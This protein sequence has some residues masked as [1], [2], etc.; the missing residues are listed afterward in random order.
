MAAVRELLDSVSAGPA[1]LALLGEAGIG[2]TTVWEAG[3]AAAREAGHAPLTCRPS[4]AE[5]RLSYAGLADLL[6]AVDAALFM[7]L[8][9]PQRRA[10]EAALLRGPGD[11]WADPRAVAAGFLSVLNGLAAS[12]PVLLA[13]DDLQWLDE[14]TRLVVGYAARRCAGPVAVLTAARSQGCGP[15]SELVPRDLA[16]IRRLYLGPLSLGALH[17]V[18]AGQLQRSFSRPILSQIAEVS[19]GNPFFAL[20]LARSMD[21]RRPGVARVPDSLRAA[22]V[23]H[24]AELGPEVRD[25]LLLVSE[26]AAPRLDLVSRALQA[27]EAGALLG[28]AEDAG[29][30]ELSGGLARFTHP[31]LARRVYTEAPPTSRRAAHRRLAEVVDDLEERARHLALAATGPDAA[32]L[33]ALNAGAAQARRRGAPAVAAELLQLALDLGA[34]DSSLRVQAARDH[35]R[36][37]DPVSAGRLAESVIRDLGSGPARAEA[38]G[39]LGAIRYDDYA[40][41]SRLL[42]QALAEAIGMPA[43]RGSIACELCFLHGSGPRVAPALRYAAITAEEA[44]RA[45]DPGLLAQGLAGL[46]ICRFL[47]GHGVNEAILAQ[48]LALEDPDRGS[49]VTIRPSLISALLRLWS[50]RLDEARAGLAAVRRRCEERG[51]ESDLGILATQEVRAACCCGDIEAL[52]RL[53]DEAAER[54]ALIGTEQAR[55][56]SLTVQASAWARLGR[57]DAA[58]AAAVEALSLFERRGGISIWSLHA[59]SALGMLEL[60]VGD[61]QSAARW[62]VPATAAMAAAGLH[63]PTVVPLLPDAVEALIGVGR[64]DDAEPL[65]Q[66]LEDSGRA[67]DRAWARAV[68]ARGRGLLLAARAD[69]DAALAAFERALAAHDSLPVGYERGRTLLAAGRLQRR[70][71]A[72]RAADAWLTEA[73]RLFDEVGAAQWA[74]V[75]QAERDRLGSR[76]GVTGR[77]TATETRV[78]GLAGSGLTNREV[79]AAL[80]VS[81]KTV[82]ANL[83]RVYRKLGIR[84]RAELG[85]YLAQQ[86][87]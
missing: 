70:R 58:R 69:L 7:P 35:F 56:L 45:G 83:T 62:L 14:P 46:V 80:L 77:L 32:T 1:V 63:E 72:R 74:A 71:N 47:L 67:P 11:A 41:A 13:I 79:A 65:V 6:D 22:V 30:I 48:A 57:V 40:E 84:S 8:P 5:I 51:E 44:R 85:R 28:P 50:Y 53:S 20:E 60:S 31:L 52:E 49:H 12:S 23:D 17:H 16:R 64:P 39:L 36:S 59:T 3:V 19:G 54:A 61:H 75:A 66:Q 78:A 37:G 33:A 10:L 43:L 24:L 81:S 25:A 86:K 68:G 87:G 29:V 26:L 55:A 9:R 21:A 2:K 76:R 34:D 82:E 27:G 42:E 15:G 73:A 18:L 38:L 4:A